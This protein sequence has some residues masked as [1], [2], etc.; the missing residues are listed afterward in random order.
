MTGCRS[1]ENSNDKESMEERA[2]VCIESHIKIRGLTFPLYTTE[3]DSQ[4]LQI[5]VHTVEITLSSVQ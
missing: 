5:L 3:Q 4:N 1:E 2:L